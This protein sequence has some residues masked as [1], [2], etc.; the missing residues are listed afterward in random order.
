[1]QRGISAA[2]EVLSKNPMGSLRC[3]KP[4]GNSPC[5]GITREPASMLRHLF[6]HPSEH[7][8]ETS[9]FNTSMEKIPI[10]GEIVG[11]N[12]SVDEST[13]RCR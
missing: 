2:A 7:D 13:R 10:V 3:N 5:L 11:V 12:F 6:G 4:Q 8:I 9:W 1:M